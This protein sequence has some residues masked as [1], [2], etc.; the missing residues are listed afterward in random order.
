VFRRHS[1]RWHSAR[2]AAQPAST[3]GEGTLDAGL[4]EVQ[5]ED[6][7]TAGEAAGDRQGYTGGGSPSPLPLTM[8]PPG[9]GSSPRKCV[10]ATRPRRA[11]L[12]VRKGQGKR[13]APK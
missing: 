13:K 1:R 11:T 9:Q 4:A 10:R 5:V 8:T 12:V 2:E 3:E 6:A 7:H